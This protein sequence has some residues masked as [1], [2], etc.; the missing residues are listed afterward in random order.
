MTNDSIELYK[1]SVLA[2][3]AY[4]NLQPGIPNEALLREIKMADLQA[5]R[6]ATDWR[7]VDRYT[8]GTGVS[9]TVFEEVATGRRYL[10]IRGT[11]PADVLDLAADYL[12]SNGFPPQ[13]N[14]QFASLR[15]RIE[16]WSANGVL[17]ANFTVTGH[18]L[19]GYLA[20][21][22]ALQFGNRVS[23]VY[24]YNA[25][26]MDGVFSP[27]VDVLRSALGVTGLGTLANL[28]NLRGTAGASVIAGLGT[29]LAPPVFIETEAS[30]NPIDHHSIVGITDA[31][32]VYDLFART[33]SSLGVESIGAILK[34]AT[35]QNAATLEAATQALG[36]V[37]LAVAPD[38]PVGDRDALYRA[39]GQ[40]R[41]AIDTLQ[42]LGETYTVRRMGLDAAADAAL[43]KTDI[44]CRF[45]LK[46]LLPFAVQGRSYDAHAAA[47]SLYDPA[48]GAGELTGDWLFDRAAML[49]WKLK[50]ATEEAQADT[51]AY[52][53][54]GAP[55]AVFKDLASGLTMNL[56][57]NWISPA[58]KRR[59]VFDGDTGTTVEGGSTNDR[60]YGAGGD[61][62]LYGYDGG[63]YL[64]G[65]TGIDTLEGGAG[66][67]ILLGGA[68]NDRLQGGAGADTYRWRKGDGLDSVEDADGAGRIQLVDGSGARYGLHR[69][70]LVSETETFKY[71]TD[72]EHGAVSYR[73][74]K[75]SKKL[76]IRFQDAAGGLDIADWDAG[77]LSL[78]L[79]YGGP[80][81]G[82]EDE[83][84]SPIQSIGAAANVYGDFQRAETAPYGPDNETLLYDSAGNAKILFNRPQP[85]D[86]TLTGTAG[87]ENMFGGAYGDSLD[88][89]DGDDYLV[90]GADSDTLYGGAGNDELYGENDAD[91]DV[92]LE[93]VAALSARS[94]SAHG[95][96]TD[97]QYS[98]YQNPVGVKGDWVAGGS[99]DDLIYGSAG[100]DG[101]AGGAG[102]DEI[103]GGA[104]ADVVWGDADI[105]AQSNR[106]VVNLDGSLDLVT[107]A[108]PRLDEVPNHYGDYPYWV[109]SA[110][111]IYAGSGN[112]TVDAGGGD[113]FVDAGAGDD[114][115]AGGT[116]ND[117]ILGGAGNDRLFGGAGL[118]A[119]FPMFSRGLD[120]HLGPGPDFVPQIAGH[121]PGQ[122][123]DAR[124]DDV[125]SGGDGN[126][127]LHSDAG[128][129][130]LSGDQG[131]DTYV[132]A[133]ISGV[134]QIEDADGINTLVLPADMT[135]G[136]LRLRVLNTADGEYLGIN[137]VEE[138]GVI[139]R[140]IVIREGLRGRGVQRFRFAGGE[141]VS[142]A[143]LL[144]QN[145]FPR[146][147]GTAR[148][149][150]SELLG[151]RADD[152]LYGGV[153]ADT[154][155][156]QSG[157]DR[158]DGGAGD[159]ILEGGAGQDQLWGGTGNDLL[160][161]GSGADTLQ[162]NA[163]DDTYVFNAGDGEDVVTDGEG[164][165]RIRFGAGIAP[166]ALTLSREGAQ[167]IRLQYGAGDAVR[168]EGG[169]VGGIASYEFADGT[170]LSREQLLAQLDNTPLNL[171]GDIAPNRLV[172]G[173]ANDTLE[174]REG[175]DHLFGGAGNDVLSGG[176]G[177]DRL[178]GGRGEDR[179]DG[180]AEADTYA[181]NLGDGHDVIAET[182]SGGT[183]AI[184]NTIA[185]G[186][187]IA[188]DTVVSH[189]QVDAE[190]GEYLVIDYGNQ[191][192]RIEIR[193]G[194][195]SD[196]WSFSFADDGELTGAQFLERTLAEP[197]NL[198]GTAADDVRS[199]SRFDDTLNGGA[200]NDRL[201]GGAGNDRLIGG[202]GTDT[203][204]GGAG[205]DT[206]IIERG[207][208][209]DTVI[210]AG[211]DNDRIELA[212]GLSIADLVASREANDLFLGVAGSED[213]LLL[214]GY[215]ASP[216]QWQFG[217]AGETTALSSVLD[218][219]ALAQQT[220]PLSERVQHYQDAFL[221]GL[222]TQMVSNV[223]TYGTVTGAGGTYSRSRGSGTTQYRDTLTIA[224]VATASDATEI[225]GTARD[226]TVSWREDLVSLTSVRVETVQ[227]PIGRYV[228]HD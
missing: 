129:D 178:D 15:E 227:V 44:A 49:G 221:N 76:E 119:G 205:S 87:T 106:W 151:G 206:Y 224:P 92:E 161:G 130:L 198:V 69:G 35:D 162:G 6:F 1:Q 45:A 187:G 24:T 47:L 29:Q 101:L 118:G 62:T 203:L 201:Q 8:D 145:D 217:P 222:T 95:L 171:Q 186:P 37:F 143:G 31:L 112:D 23:A 188:L 78:D 131:D 207:M 189:R 3:A 175:S 153:G 13:M 14:L 59:I 120:A 192:D 212:A 64:E 103:H 46:E 77:E 22:V 50:Q 79:G 214:K 70:R 110:D 164:I 202:T 34:A 51:T 209:R 10:A 134:V 138:N 55:D 108:L 21:A 58:A 28:T 66:N 90:G 32:A 93:D 81:S 84:A 36:K 218:Q 4:A 174:G 208:G 148:P 132:V 56:G 196:A 123:F 135:P 2:M 85:R 136:S 197:L 220:R 11:E 147:V 128:N 30:V 166:A 74:D 176:D 163:G 219:V 181:F 199:G 122:P 83:P 57:S 80:L 104:G 99:G 17:P 61:D 177:W 19:G 96:D 18:S 179:L 155:R 16:A 172:G 150:G 137:T 54:G 193:D 182:D 170:V 216:K 116:G 9:A 226:T 5:S 20:D 86:D 159:D 25:P 114:L 146:F 105:V 133:A 140:G 12:L 39:Y 149:E 168:I 109:G 225:A 142:L 94:R 40:I 67:D 124:D 160:L 26:G 68:G 121:A 194:L 213:G 204:E 111:A 73:L 65:G 127:V 152:S 157:N 48:T 139:V 210:E 195:R 126:D 113:D 167:D 200:G 184:A 185:F 91:T 141:E 144:E 88:G 102:S 100:N 125:L 115:I 98:G 42:A 41:E 211:T 72:V 33:D 223:F 27:L 75:N 165:N 97:A 82:A 156:G 38:I 71:W 190:G 154:L 169:F 53:K 89:R 191:G 117:L 7:V 60:L 183:T 180:G 228:P 215:F 63:D 107:G 43:A 173:N 158:L 52:G